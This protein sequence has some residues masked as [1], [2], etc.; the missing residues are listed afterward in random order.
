MIIYIIDTYFFNIKII[1]PQIISQKGSFVIVSATTN[2]GCQKV[3]R[4]N[5]EKSWL[6]WKHSKFPLIEEV[7][8]DFGENSKKYFAAIR[9]THG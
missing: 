8:D 1:N 4:A 7:H 3:H 6:K 9:K 2:C 5:K